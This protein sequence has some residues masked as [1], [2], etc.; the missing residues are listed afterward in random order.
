MPLDFL[1]HFPWSFFVF[2]IFFQTATFKLLLG[3]VLSSQGEKHIMKKFFAFAAMVLALSV[4]LAVPSAQA[5]TYVNG[6][7]ANYPP[8][9]YM[10]EKGQPAG[11][12]VE[13]MNWIADKMGFTIE[14]K[15]IAWDGI[16]PALLARQIDM[17]CSGMSITPERSQMVTFSNPYWAVSRV[18]LVE[19][20]S[21]LTP[22]S[23]LSKQPILLGVQRGTS[24]ASDIQKEQ[25][26]KG[27][28]F[29]LRF[30]E[31]SPLIVE[32]LINGRIDAG[33]M[34]AL[35]A[36]Y[37]IAQGKAVKK[38][39]IHGTPDQFGVALRKDDAELRRLVNEGYKL[40][41]ADP[42]WQVLKDKYL[43]EKTK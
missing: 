34:D 6:I 32:D 29:T 18:F 33:L 13:S 36:E 42:H 17:V 23:I 31:S 10:D 12:D 14:H 16:I 40:L 5:K 37:A 11:F 21:D 27:Y 15:P 2:G 43:K 8:F 30:Y 19:K 25:K 20:N 38:A 7:D 9:G 35:P 28:P 3:A 24:E 4:S 41:M 26:E 22:A 1:L 39:G